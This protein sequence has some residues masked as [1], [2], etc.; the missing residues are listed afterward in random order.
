MILRLIIGL[1]ILYLLF[2]LLR[3]PAPRVGGGGDRAKHRTR[4]LPEDLVED[5]VCHTY[6]PIGE[7]RCLKVDGKTVYF[8]SSKCQEEFQKE[9]KR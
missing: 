5:P 6:I 9:Q 1:F 8:C 3:K 2:R 7:A 4:A